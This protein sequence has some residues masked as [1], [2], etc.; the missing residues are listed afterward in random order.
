M[1]ALII[2]GILMGLIGALAYIK[3][4][5]KPNTLPVMRFTNPNYSASDT[6]SK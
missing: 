2:G 5:K 1:F 4:T 3:V 6:E